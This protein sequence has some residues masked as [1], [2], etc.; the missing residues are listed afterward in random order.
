MVAAIAAGAR[1]EASEKP[2]SISDATSGL[3]K[4]NGYFDYYWDNDAGKVWLEI[5]QMNEEFLYV[6]YLSRGLG[7]NDVGLDRGQIGDSYL[8]YFRRIGP[9]V[10]MMQRNYRFRAVSDDPEERRAVDESFAQSTLWGFEVAAEEGSRVLVDATDFLLRDARDVAG[11]LRRSRQGS[12]KLESGRS[13]IDLERTKNFPKNSEFEAILTFTADSA[14]SRVREV[15]PTPTAFTIQQHH[16]FVELPDTGF[17]PRGYDIRSGYFAIEY[18][19]FATPLSEPITKRFIARHRLHKKDQTARVSEPVEPIVYYVDPGAPEP[20]R[21][22]LVEGASWWNQAFEAAGYK[23]AFRVEVLPDTADPLDLRYNMIQWVHRSTRGWSYGGSVIDPRTGEILKGHVTLGSLRARQ[24][25]LIAE[26]L[27]QP[28]ELGS[29][30]T[31][32]QMQELALARIRQL[33]AHEVGHTLGLRHNYAASTRD[34]ASVMD[35]PYPFVQFDSTGA[36]DL[37]QAYTSGIGRW[38]RA[39]IMYGYS[40]FPAQADLDRTLASLLDSVFASGQRYLS[41]ADA[42]PEGSASPNAHL[43]D[44]GANAVDELARLLDVRSKLLAQFSERAIRSGA[45]LVML[46][47]ALVPIYMFHR[48]Q[49]EACA[50]SLGGIDY[51]FS[52]RGSGPQTLNPVAADEQWRS[53]KALLLCLEPPALAIPDTLLKLIPP[54]TTELPR[55]REIFDRRTGS[56]FDPL[57]AAESVAD[58]VVRMILNSDRAARLVEQKARPG[59]LPGLDEVIDRLVSVTWKHERTVGLDAEIQRTV[60][61]LVLHH[62]IRLAADPGALPQARALASQQLVGLK[63]WCETQVERISNEGQ[64]AHLNSAAQTIGRYLDDPSEFEFY[65]PLDPPAGS[66]IGDG[67]AGWGCDWE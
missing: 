46:E 12:F 4:H 47:E 18:M 55:S 28:Y 37:S 51:A 43:W 53:L 48:Y 45:P 27:L 67:H 59:G 23:D 19:D 33:S 9:K 34:R 36:I 14:G 26:G 49:I 57:G 3:E 38:D 66:P 62:L 64:R 56:A 22:A 13:A 63:S 29:D 10:L 60:D 40:D 24:D 39:A 7:S 54:Q 32:P 8:V 31:S 16:S 61:N 42:R 41:D 35:Y 65:R 44:N 5:D 6:T 50:K 20:I 17:T 21:S 2:K 58:L 25:Y 1:A 11:S 15:A 30:S 52:V